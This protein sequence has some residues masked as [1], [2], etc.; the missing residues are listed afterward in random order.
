MDQYHPCGEFAGL[1]D[2]AGTITGD[3]YQQ[4]I[5]AAEAVGLTR[6]DRKDLSALIK[7][8]FSS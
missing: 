4:A 1:A 2:T 6:L 8:L 5:K 7:R 3:M